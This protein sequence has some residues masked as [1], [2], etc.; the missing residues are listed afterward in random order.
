ML[1]SDYDED[2]DRTMRVLRRD[3][4]T[5]EEMEAFHRDGYVI[6]PGIMYDGARA[7][8]HDELLGIEQTF[9]ASGP[10]EISAP[11]YLAMSEGQRAQARDPRNSIAPH[12]F[13]PLRNWDCKGPVSDALMDAPL[14]MGFLEAI[15]G[16]KFNL[17]H[18]SMNIT[19]RGHAQ[20][21]PPDIFPPLHQDAG[22]STTDRIASYKSQ[23]SQ[24]DNYSEER[25][26]WYISC[27][28]YVDGLQAGDGSLCVVPG[29]HRLPPVQ[30][31]PGT[32]STAEAGARLEAL[33]VEHG[34]VPQMLDLPPGSLIIHNSMCYHGVEPK[35]SDAE[36]EHRV[37]ADYIY[38]SYQYPRA[39][40]QPIPLEWLTSVKDDPARYARRKILFDRP[41]GSM[42]G[43][44]Y[45]EPKADEVLCVHHIRT[46]RL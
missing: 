8:F 16:P 20:R 3:A 5:T 45:P 10:C 6:F 36:K 46:A 27:F 1:P 17:C 7:T 18:C 2:A 41:I 22:A 13:G 29:S 39:R 11:R 21:L 14:P 43:N 25:D 19:S 9:D 37:F 15:M 35:P 32:L 4:H 42:Y 26:D 38:K 23:Q 24:F 30:T 12:Q 44:Q 28:Y 33:I 31:V 40:T 34:L